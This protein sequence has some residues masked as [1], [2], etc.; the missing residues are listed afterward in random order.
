MVAAA[1]FRVTGTEG[2]EGNVHASRAW[3][4]NGEPQKDC[5]SPDRF[6]SSNAILSKRNFA[7]RSSLEAESRR[8]VS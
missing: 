6:S 4:G 3:K 5:L 8:V 1:V 2:V 7:F